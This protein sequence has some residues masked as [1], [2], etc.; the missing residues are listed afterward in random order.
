ML[1]SIRTLDCDFRNIKPEI[2]DEL[3]FLYEFDT[4]MLLAMNSE[5]SNIIP[6]IFP[7]LLLSVKIE[8]SIFSDE[9]STLINNV[10][11]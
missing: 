7:V 11:P 9:D 1:L 5:V 8:F 6:F 4:V 2:A 10:L 3:V